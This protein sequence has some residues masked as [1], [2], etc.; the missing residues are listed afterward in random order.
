MENTDKENC[1]PK[2]FSEGKSEIIEHPGTTNVD[3]RYVQ[4]V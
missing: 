2:F 1:A 4:R 3:V